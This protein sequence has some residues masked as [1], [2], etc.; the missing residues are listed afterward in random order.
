MGLLLLQV[1][2]CVLTARTCLACLV[3]TVRGPSSGDCYSLHY[4]PLSWFEAETV[5][6]S[7]G[8]HLASVAGPTLN[9]F[10]NQ[11]SHN[12]C[13]ADYWLGASTVLNNLWRWLD[14][15]SFNYT[16]WATGRFQRGV[17]NCTMIEGHFY[18]LFRV[19]VWFEPTQ[20]PLAHLD[21]EI[22]KKS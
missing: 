15:S 14:G 20:D 16:N 12:W 5:C 7:N 18:P 11:L 13:Y 21:H 9:F 8:A 6:R 22:I 4:L 19:V 10:T 17:R 3:G 2:L 1:L